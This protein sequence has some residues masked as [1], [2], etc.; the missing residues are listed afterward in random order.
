MAAPSQHFLDTHPVFARLYATGDSSLW[1]SFL[2]NH[3]T[4]SQ[5]FMRDQS[6]QTAGPAPAPA[7]TP[8]PAAGQSDTPPPPA[9][10]YNRNAYEYVKGLFDSYGLGSLAPQILQYAQQGIEDPQVMEVLL[11]Q[12]PE[13]KQRFAA[14]E[15]RVAAGLNALSISQYLGLENQYSAILR[16]SG[17]P[18][19]FYDSKDD[20]TNWIANDVSA[21]EVQERVTAAQQA[22]MSSDP[23]VRRM[24]SDYY[25]LGDGDLTAYFLDQGRAHTL[26]ETR[27]TLGTAQ[28]GAAAA[29][30]GLIESKD[31]AQLFYD[32]GVTPDQ[33]AS[34]FATVAEALPAA[35]HLS[36]IY[37]GQ[38]AGVGQTTLED[39]F[40]GGLASAR[41]ARERLAGLESASFSESS[42]LSA[43]SLRRKTRGAY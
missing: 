12:T 13:F 39:E 26:F 14:N 7:P 41:R 1:R 29:R 27:R 42:G 18:S 22:V 15:K 24:L 23:T 19:N 16:G 43:T 8:P 11:R 33:A 9:P 30:Q 37:G 4:I 40:L 10:T 32:Q 3:P 20:F 35:Q 36:S 2:L 17:L 28:I 5:E 25:G 6:R 31:R 21:D 38:T 34:G